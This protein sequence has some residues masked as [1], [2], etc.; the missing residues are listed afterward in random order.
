MQY[1]A[2]AQRKGPLAYAGKELL[3]FLTKHGEDKWVDRLMDIKDSY[4]RSSFTAVN[5]G[6]KYTIVL[7]D[8]KEHT[9]PE[10]YF[11]FGEGKG[12]YRLRK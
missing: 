8:L 3:E 9:E 11:T 7:L 10:G 1:N 12:I 2:G 6:L 5:S 4:Q